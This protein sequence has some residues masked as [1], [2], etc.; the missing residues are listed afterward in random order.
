MN[1]T[2]YCGVDL[3]SNTAMYVITD[4][5]DRALFQRRLPNALPAVLESLARMA[6]P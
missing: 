4:Q 3:H 2:L 1:K 6:L 5:Q